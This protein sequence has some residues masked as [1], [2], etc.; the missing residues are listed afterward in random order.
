MKETS[1]IGAPAWLQGVQTTPVA[2][3]QVDFLQFLDEDGVLTQDP[4]PITENTDL[5]VRMYRSMVVHRAFDQKAV[6]LQRTGQLGTYAAGLGQEAIGS[7]LGAAM[8]PDDV[9]LPSYRESAA[10]FWRGVRMASILQYWSGDERAM[11]YDGACPNDFPITVTIGAQTTHAVGVAYAL[12]LRGE[13]LAA[14]C[15]V[16]D[17]G[18]SKG[19]FYEGIN[20]AGVWKLP[21]IYLVSNNQWA[22]SLPSSR[23]TAA[24]TFAQKAFAAGV[25]TLQV[26]GNDLLAVYH[27]LQGAL[28][29]T[30]AGNGPVLIEAL[31]YRLHDHTTADDAS[32][33]RP[34]EELETAWQKEPIGRLRRYLESRQLWDEQRETE[35][36]AE[37]KAEVDQAVGEYLATEPEPPEALMFDHLY[38]HLPRALKDQRACAERWKEGGNSHG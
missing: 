21:L 3:C 13:G 6:A 31:T 12:K 34:K 26:D 38:G 33:Y 10:L 19:D 11:R 15:S 5:L 2:R 29:Y 28:E 23:Q 20:A 36:E 35:L 27:A 9:L 37:A 4:P 24:P 30:R 8:R 16:G 18:T 32:R 1:E 25:E 22:I 14:V 7:A 17:G